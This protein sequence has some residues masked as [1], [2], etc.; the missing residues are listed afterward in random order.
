MFPPRIEA[1]ART[2]GTPL[3]DQDRWEWLETLKATAILRMRA[4]NHDCIIVTCSAL[5]QSYRA[6]LRNSRVFR[7]VFVT[8]EAA[9]EILVRRVQERKGHFMGGKMVE[10][11]L[12]V[13]EAP[14]I[15]ETDVIPVDVSGDE[16]GVVEEVMGILGTV[17][18]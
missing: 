12:E 15:E 9:K 14:G 6:E 8:L 18:R 5:K 4:E 11:Q 1:E 10:S 16:E 2:S 17:L 3:S 7:A 13:L